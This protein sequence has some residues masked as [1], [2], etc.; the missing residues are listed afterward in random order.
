MGAVIWR[1]GVCAAFA[2]NSMLYTL[3]GYF[4]M[5]S[6]FAFAPHFEWL[7]FLFATASMGLGGTYFILRAA[8]AARNG[9]IHLDLP[10]SIGLIVGYSVSLY[11]W[12][13]GDESLLYFDF[14]STFVFL[15][16]VGR[17]AQLAAIDR[18]RSRLAKQSAVAPR[19][20]IRQ[21]DGRFAEREAEALKSEDIYRIGAGDWAPVESTLRSPEARMGMEWINGESVPS[22]FLEG[23]LVPSGARQLGTGVLELVARESWEGSLL[24]RLTDRK[25][26][27]SGRDRLLQVWI[28]R[29][30]KRCVCRM[31]LCR[32]NANGASG[33]RSDPCD[34]VSLRPGGGVASARSRFVDA[35]RGCEGAG[36]PTGSYCGL[37]FPASPRRDVARLE[38]SLD[39]F[40]SSGSFSYDR[41]WRE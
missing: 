41:R 14:V 38:G 30:R 20:E 37:A 26:E 8:R 40:E 29:Y 6:D 11:G 33:I 36:E 12:T 27:R 9:V 35:K 18:N 31:D 25:E 2:L 19:V 28:S 15:M 23:S 5:E 3:P 39:R 34:F 21:A 16:L 13:S 17:W 22:S 32:R 4:G 10:I 24:K 7:S 1:L